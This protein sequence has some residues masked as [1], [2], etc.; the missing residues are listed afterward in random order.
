MK[1]LILSAAAVT[2]LGGPALAQTNPNQDRHDDGQHQRPANAAPAR[3]YAPAARGPAS[4]G[5]APTYRAPQNNY[6]APRSYTPQTRSPM[7]QGGAT[8]QPPANTSG[9]YHNYRSYPGTSAG[10]YQGSRQGQYQGYRQGQYQGQYQGYRQG[11]Y[12]GYPQGQY[13]GYRQGQYQGYRQGQYQGY[14]NTWNN[15]TGD[16]WRGHRG[17]EGYEGRR[18]GFW[19]APGW[20]YYN[21]DPRWYDYD[22]EVGAIVPYQFRSYYVNDPYDYGLPPAPY[23]AAWI[24]LGDRIVLVDLESGQIIQLAYGY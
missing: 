5:Y 24:F 16:W 17:W 3:S 20:G 8:Y 2:L 21:V 1:R 7:I 11:Q 18:S 9:Q 23:G 14:S 13:Q 4:Q 22:W 12:Q 19:F 6:A 15:R 10:Q